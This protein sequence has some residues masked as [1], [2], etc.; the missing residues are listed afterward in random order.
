MP[1][2]Q[3]HPNSLKNLEKGQWK[4]GQSGNPSGR[5][6]PSF[7]PILQKIL[8]KDYIMKDPLLKKKSKKKIAEWLMLRL[9]GNALGGK[10]KSLDMLM[11]RIDGA[12]QKSI[13]LEAS[14]STQINIIKDKIRKN[15]ELEDDDK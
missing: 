6:S 4:P 12:V 3:V 10:E 14:D 2:R 15:L 5:Q 11:D 13:K 9:V 8:D 7:M 1:K